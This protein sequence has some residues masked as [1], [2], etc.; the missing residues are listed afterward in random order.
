MNIFYRTINANEA[1]ILHTSDG[2]PV[3]C[4]PNEFTVY[5]IDSTL[6]VAYDHPEGLVIAVNDAR[7]IGIPS[8]TEAPL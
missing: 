1:V 5:P 2:A 4:L 8:E 7:R 6:S 3:T